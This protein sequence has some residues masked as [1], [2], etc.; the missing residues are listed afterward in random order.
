MERAGKAVLLVYFA[1]HASAIFTTIFGVRGGHLLHLEKLRTWHPYIFFW[2]YGCDWYMK[3]AS[4]ALAIG[5][6]FKIKS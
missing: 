5:T 1:L 3:M 4:S 6:P 2:G